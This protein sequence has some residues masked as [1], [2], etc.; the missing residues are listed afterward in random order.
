[1]VTLLLLFTSL[2]MWGLDEMTTMIRLNP[3]DEVLGSRTV[4]SCGHFILVKTQKVTFVQ[5]TGVSPT[6]AHLVIHSQHSLQK[7]IGFHT[8]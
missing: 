5:P 4:A 2:F 7:S 1:M 3:Q 8:L 6:Q